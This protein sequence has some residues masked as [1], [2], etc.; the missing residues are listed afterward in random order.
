MGAS[1]ALGNNFIQEEPSQVEKVKTSEM[2]K[3]IPYIIG[4][5]AAERFSY[6]GMRTILVVFMTQYLMGRNGQLATMS[7]AQASSWYHLF[8]SANYFFP[9]IGAF[10]SDIFWGKYNSFVRINFFRQKHRPIKKIEFACRGRS[11]F[12]KLI[13]N[14][15]YRNL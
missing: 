1:T 13:R 5:E 6:Y 10:V 11:T 8:M 3:G 9:I 14:I 7:D 12:P 15:F 2:P 4:N